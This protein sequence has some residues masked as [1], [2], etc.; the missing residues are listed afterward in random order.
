MR[1]IHVL[2]FPPGRC[3]V[4]IS[5]LPSGDHRGLELSVLGDVRRCASPPAVGTIHTSRWY[6]LSFS[7]TVCTVNA[8]R[9]ASGDIA[10]AG[11][12]IAASVALSRFDAR[13]ARWSRS[14]AVQGDSSR[15]QVV[16][17]LTWVTET[18]LTIAAAAT[19]G[20]GRLTGSETVA[21]AG[22]HATEAMV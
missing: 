9:L 8:M 3:D 4:K 7:F 14:A 18:Q 1:S 6:L 10:G 12:A 16:H 11:V 5:S 13:I 20:V 15:F 21:D 17:H 2:P 22:L 19:W